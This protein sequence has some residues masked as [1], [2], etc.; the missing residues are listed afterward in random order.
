MQQN[1]WGRRQGT[2]PSQ[3]RFDQARCSTSL[4]AIRALADCASH[5]LAGH[6]SAPRP[7]RPTATQALLDTSHSSREIHI[8]A[9]ADTPSRSS[10]FRISF[11]STWQPVDCSDI[12][13]DT[14]D[15]SLIHSLTLTAARPLYHLCAEIATRVLTVFCTST[16]PSRSDHNCHSQHCTLNHHRSPATHFIIL[17]AACLCSLLAASA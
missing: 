10:T 17:L 15:V 13:T 11:T 3:P 2:L 16:S 12:T 9:R 8:T 4:T 1:C 5:R 6:L 7:L 14:A